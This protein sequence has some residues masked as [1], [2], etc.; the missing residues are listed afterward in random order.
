MSLLDVHNARVIFHGQGM[1]RRGPQKV[2]VDGVSLHMER[3]EWL[4]LV[5]ESGSGKSTLGR[6][7]AALQPLDEGVI[8]FEGK[9]VANF[10]RSTAKT[11]R[12]KVQMIFQDPLGA[13][14]PRMT[15]GQALAEVLRVHRLA[16][17]DEA[18]S[19]AGELLASVGLDM[20][21]VH[22][23]PHEFSGGQRQRIGIARALALDPELL[24]ADEPVS[25]LDVS[26]QAQI[27][28]LL[29]Q[30]HRE[31]GFACLFIAHDLAVVRH[32]CPRVM[33]MQTGRIV[34]EGDAERVFTRPVHPY[35]R[36]LLDAVPD[37]DRAL[38]TR[39]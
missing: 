21:A 35:T 24:I 30:L 16:T 7:M 38:K 14:N 8:R 34:E 1:R 27:L 32:M 36:I 39:G 26:V 2:A 4:G 25:S 10:N 12:R 6:A 19:R 9:D 31:R 11:F 29:K 33:V 37:I 13:L 17:G 28:N 22:R 20:R 18:K 3:G 5:G 23:Y 15:V